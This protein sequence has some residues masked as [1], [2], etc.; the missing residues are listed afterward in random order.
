MTAKHETSYPTVELVIGKF[1]DWLKHRRELSEIR[2]MNRSKQIAIHTISFGA[3]PFMKALAEE[4][5]GRYV[6]VK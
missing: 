5:A 6:E 3:S 2:R 1:V 4:N